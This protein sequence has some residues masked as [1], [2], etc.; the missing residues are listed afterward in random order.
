MEDILKFIYKEI[1]SNYNENSDNLSLVSGDAGI[2]LFYAYYGHYIDQNAL[3]DYHKLSEKIFMKINSSQ[4]LFFNY[5]EGLTGLF[6]ALLILKKNQII[7]NIN[8]ND[9]DF[10]DTYFYKKCIG[11]IEDGNNDFFYGSA[12]ITYYFNLKSDYFQNK[13]CINYQFKILKKLY[14][15]KNINNRI[16]NSK[17]KINDQIEI[18][19]PH[20]LSSW[21]IILAKMKKVLNYKSINDMQMNIAQYVIPYILKDSGNANFSVFPTIIND[22]TKFYKN[23]LSRLGWCYGDLPCLL[24]TLDYAEQI[25]DIELINLIISKLQN[26]SHKKEYEKYSV[27]DNGICHGNS[28]IALIFILLFKRFYINDF[29]LGSNFWKN[30]IQITFDTDKNFYKK[31]KVNNDFVSSIEYGMLEGLAGIGLFLI[32]EYT[33]DYSW[34][35]LLLLK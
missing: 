9:F 2:L 23:N 8:V 18:S 27:H 16:F 24:S 11:Y 4:R 32:S 25:K 22:G 29:L 21:L 31:Y 20:G 7:N 13:N 34:K 12:G 33:D 6:S 28:G 35:D 26:V 15:S 3:N 19:M 14:E 17:E 10:F 1:K 5:A 30:R